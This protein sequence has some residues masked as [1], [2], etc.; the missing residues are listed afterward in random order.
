MDLELKQKRK[1][2]HPA[3]YPIRTHQKHLY[4]HRSDQVIRGLT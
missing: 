2:V 4:M 1:D 3:S